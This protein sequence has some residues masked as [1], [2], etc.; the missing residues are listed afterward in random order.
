M[1]NTNGNGQIRNVDGENIPLLNFVYVIMS[2]KVNI[3]VQ[4]R[5]RV[6]DPYFPIILIYFLAKIKKIKKHTHIAICCNN[7][8]TLITLK[9]KNK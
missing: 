8:I 7:S 5:E 2:V 1:N 3:V 9:L 6:F 4:K